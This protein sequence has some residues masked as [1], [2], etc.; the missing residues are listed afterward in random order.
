MYNSKIDWN[1]HGEFSI[2]K[3][4]AFIL[5]IAYH[6]SLYTSSSRN[7][8]I[9]LLWKNNTYKSKIELISM[10]RIATSWFVISQILSFSFEY[11]SISAHDCRSIFSYL[12]NT[13]FFLQLTLT[14]DCLVPHG[15]REIKKMTKKEQ[16]NTWKRSTK[17]KKE[18]LHHVPKEFWRLYHSAYFHGILFIY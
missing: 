10:S 13:F 2:S 11:F 5:Y 18:K 3:N 4:F 6:F 7:L 14:D 9:R 16:N 8:E 12:I 1:K 17:K 15:K